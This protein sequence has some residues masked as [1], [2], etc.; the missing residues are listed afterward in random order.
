MQ[1][2]EGNIQV[3]LLRLG[4][5]TGGRPPAHH[6]EYGHRRLAGHRQADALGHQG[7]AG[8]GGCRKRRYSAKS[9]TDRHID[10]RQLV[11]RLQ[12]LPAQLLQAARHPLQHIRG[13]GDGI[14]GDKTD[15]GFQRPQTRRLV[16][17]EVP[18]T[19]VTPGWNDQFAARFG[20]RAA[21]NTGG[22]RLAIGRGLAGQFLRGEV[23]HARRRQAQQA[24]QHAQGEHID[25][26]LPV[27]GRRQFSEG[28]MNDLRPGCRHGCRQLTA[29]LAQHQAVGPQANLVL[30]TIEIIPIQGHHQVVAAGGGVALIRGQLQQGGGLAAANLR[31]VGLAQQAAASLPGPGLQQQLAAGNHPGTT[32]AGYCD[33]QLLCTHGFMRHTGNQ[34]SIAPPEKYGTG[35]RRFLALTCASS[36]EPRPRRP[37][38]RAPGSACPGRG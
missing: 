28:D 38:G 11:L 7:Q 5:D 27:A 16:A 3:A 20:G 25:P 10:C 19:A 26:P 21:L 29:L 14:G 17:A 32:G 9:R 33:G 31:T 4:G 15:A 12:Q 23:R 30:E 18:G 37:A 22:G 8:A 6:I 35:K 1:A 24:S 36:R 34:P 13:R 2:V